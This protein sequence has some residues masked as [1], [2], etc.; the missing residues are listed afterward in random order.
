MGCVV[1]QKRIIPSPSKDLT[2]INQRQ[3]ITWFEIVP[4]MLS[5]THVNDADIFRLPTIEHVTS[6]V[7]RVLN[8][9]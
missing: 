3:Q 7:K 4:D 2:V 1:V 8:R 9:A 5:P 6:I